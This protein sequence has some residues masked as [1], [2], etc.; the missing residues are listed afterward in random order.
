MVTVAPPAMM[1]IAIRCTYTFS[2]GH[3]C[4]HVIARIP[5]EKWEDEGVKA[6]EGYCKRHNAPWLFGDCK[7][8]YKSLT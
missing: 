3:L 6:I 8:D 1:K 2:D 4:N 5:V 7:P